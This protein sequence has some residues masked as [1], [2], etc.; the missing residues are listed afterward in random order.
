[1]K[2]FIEKIT[3]SPKINATITL[4]LDQR[5]KSRLK[6]SLDS[7]EEVGLF[8]GRGDVL[9]HGDLIMTNDGFIAQ[10][11]AAPEKLSSIY[12]ED[13]LLLARACYHLGNRHVALQI[14]KSS[15]H[16]KYDHVLDDMIRSFGLNL[17]SEELPFSPESGAYSQHSTDHHAHDHE[18]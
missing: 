13:I 9:K 10:V 11:I 4:T 18:Y 8:M 17:I 12:T 16:Y 3:S 5:V 6:T 15:V 2:E 14:T 1:M 7:G